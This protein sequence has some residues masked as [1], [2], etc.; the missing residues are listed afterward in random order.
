M[1]MASA[2]S[3]AAPSSEEEEQAPWRS[4]WWQLAPCARTCTG[5]LPLGA[6]GFSA[7]TLRSRGRESA[8]SACAAAQHKHNARR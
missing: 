3:A 1:A 6:K 2:A 5:R 7:W 8:L 4:P